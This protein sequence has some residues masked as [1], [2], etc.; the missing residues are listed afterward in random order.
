MSEVKGRLAEESQSPWK[1]LDVSDGHFLTSVVISLNWDFKSHIT[2]ILNEQ[3]SAVV[4]EA[5]D[6]SYRTWVGCDLV[7][8]GIAATWKAFADR[9]KAASAK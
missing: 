9:A 7:E 2:Q 4:A 5:D 6:G 1:P 8:H 3:W